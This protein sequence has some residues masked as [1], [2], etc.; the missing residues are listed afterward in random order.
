M[1]L[2][3]KDRTPFFAVLG[4]LAL[5]LDDDAQ[6]NQVFFAGV[7]YAMRRPLRA[8]MHNAR[9]K[10]LFDAVANGNARAFDDVVQIIA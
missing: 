3:S 4:R 6:Q 8:D 2:L 7:S 5:T 1:R 10:L 9:Q